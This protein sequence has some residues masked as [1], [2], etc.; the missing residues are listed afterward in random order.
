MKRKTQQRQTAAAENHKEREG[1]LTDVNKQNKKQKGALES[2]AL[3]DPQRRAAAA[4][5]ARAFV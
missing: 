1:T 3:A 4:S 5:N 2:E